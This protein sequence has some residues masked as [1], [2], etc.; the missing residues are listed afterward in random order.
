M[1]PTFTNNPPRPFI[2]AHTLLRGQQRGIK[3][4]ARDIVFCHADREERAGAGMLRLSLSRHQIR[5]LV[6]QGIISP[7][8]AD[9]CSR[10]TIVTDERCIVTNYRTS[11]TH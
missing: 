11:R 6:A 9:R 3:Q 7:Q 2:C 4:S 1:H 10:L 5:S 8:Q